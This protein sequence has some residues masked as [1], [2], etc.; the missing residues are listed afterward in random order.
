MTK[1]ITMIHSNVASIIDGNLHIDRK[2]LTGMRS[3]ATSINAKLLTLHPNNTSNNQIMDEVVVPITDL[4]FE[5]ATIDSSSNYSTITNLIAEH[6]KS[7]DLVYGYTNWGATNLAKKLGI[8]YI[9]VLEYDLATHITISKLQ[10]RSKLRRLSRI[11]KTTIRYLFT[12]CI[13]ML[14]ASALH[15]NGYP[16]YLES[17]LLNRN[18]LLYLDSRMSEGMVIQLDI[19]NSRLN[20]ASTRPLKLLF[21]GRYEMIKGAT[22]VIHI[23]LECLRQGVNIELQCF[24]KGSLKLEM[25][26]LA[27]TAVVPNRIHINDQI[28]YPELVLRSYESDL[29]ICCHI[30]SDPSCTYLESFGAGLPIVGYGN[31]MWKGL[32][33]ESGAGHATPVWDRQAAVKAVKELSENHSRLTEMSLKARSFALA[34]TFENEFKK[35]TEDINLKLRCTKTV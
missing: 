32:C 31:T 6:I 28:P 23:A 9:L 14:G 34:H 5:V 13:A 1:K 10:V 15:C 12:D 27:S 19:L 30:Q 16:A 17:R 18:Q 8:P 35:R 20:S 4:N 22:E 25:Q 7:S 33:A 11:L 26:Q 3:Y 29:F 24:G 21:S 2:F